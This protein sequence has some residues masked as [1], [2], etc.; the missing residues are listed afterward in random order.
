MPVRRLLAERVTRWPT[1]FAAKLGEHLGRR[2]RD[3]GDI[4][5]Q[6][7]VSDR[8]ED[9]T[10]AVAVSFARVE[11]RPDARDEGSR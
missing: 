10:R 5:M 4:K 8:T 2:H 7:I 3:D 11:H 9:D 1:G 6:V